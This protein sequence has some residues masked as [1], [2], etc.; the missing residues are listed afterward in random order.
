MQPFRLARVAAQ[1]EGLRL[2]GY[3]RRQMRRAI[4]AAIAVAFFLA[5]LALGEVAGVLALVARFP[6]I[7]AVLIVLG[8]NLLLALLF[9]ALALSSRPGVSEVEA[10]RLRETA[11]M[12][13]LRLFST[14]SL[15][16]VATRVLRE[17]LQR[18]RDRD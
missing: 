3:L 18:R 17:A 16:G 15:I 13:M 7:E 9:L 4:F 5:A 12:E 8:G 6:V 10:L 2:R 11:R 14:A 1:A